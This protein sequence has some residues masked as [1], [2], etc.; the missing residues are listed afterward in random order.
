MSR[1][2][3]SV[4]SL[5]LRPAVF[6]VIAGVIFLGIS[7]ATSGL[8]QSYSVS[9]NLIIQ[10]VLSPEIALIAVTE[11][12]VSIGVVFLFVKGEV[13]LVIYS[14]VAIATVNLTQ[15]IY[16]L[17]STG[18]D[19]NTAWTNQETGI[20]LSAVFIIFGAVVG[21]LARTGRRPR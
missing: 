5:L 20:I 16:N 15:L 13:G 9:P 8:F 7:L 18:G 2:G 1:M 19:F 21:S 11:I 4:G 3:G 10:P 17:T 12:L 14:L 6:G